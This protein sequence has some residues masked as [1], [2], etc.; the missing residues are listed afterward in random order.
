MPSGDS[1]IGIWRTAGSAPTKPTLGVG[2]AADLELKWSADTGGAV[3]LSGPSIANGRVFVASY[4]GLSAFDQASGD[5]IWHRAI[6]GFVESSP[7]VVNG[8]VF[9]LT[10][11]GAAQAYR[12][13]DGKPLWSTQTGGA[14]AGPVVR[15]GI[16]FVGGS[17]QVFALNAATGATVWSAEAPFMRSPPSVVGARVYVAGDNRVAAF[18][19]ATGARIWIKRISSVQISSPVVSGNRIYVGTSDDGVYCLFAGR[20]AIAWHVGLGRLMDNSPSVDGARMYVGDY[21]TNRIVAYDR[22]TGAFLWASHGG[23]SQGSVSVANGVAWAAGFDGTL[24]GIDVATGTVLVTKD[25]GDYSTS[26]P[27]IVD[28][29]VYVGSDSGALMAFGLPE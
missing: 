3:M 1:S 7:A 18:D 16:V 11:D 17:A 5:P 25:L 8:R 10:N 2:N 19:A 15:D 23:G 22:V 14:I 27:A 29:V 21:G 28:G 26:T 12:S 13:W 6:E 9:I 4:G 20:G 24:Y